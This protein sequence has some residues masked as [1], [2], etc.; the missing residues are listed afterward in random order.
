MCITANIHH[1]PASYVVSALELLLWVMG[2][3]WNTMF[4]GWS[5]YGPKT[6]WHAPKPK[7]DIIIITPDYNNNL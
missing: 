3:F 4:W 5:L 6:K 7:K 2:G 1:D